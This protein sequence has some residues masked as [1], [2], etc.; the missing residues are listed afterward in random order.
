MKPRSSPTAR[1]DSL[2]VFLALVQFVVLLYGAQLVAVPWWPEPH[3]GPVSVF[4]MST[5]FECIAHSFIHHPFFRSRRLNGA[6]SV[7]N[8][9]LIGSPQAIYRLHH[10][11]ITNTT[12]TPP[13]PR[14]APP[15]TCPPPGDTAAGPGSRR[16]SCP[17]PCWATSAPT[18]ASSG[19]ARKRHL[20][21]RVYRE[22]AAVLA[23]V[24]AIGWL[25]P[26]GLVFFYLPVWY[27]GN[28]AAQAENFLEH[29]GAS[30]ATGRPTR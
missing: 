25:N 26:M 17:M 4:L 9:L 2:L 3:R 15:R 8:S 12:T 30:R 29:Y 20:I 23:L 27:F 21:R 10:L 24:V 6:F 1:L 19:E 7:F 11:T 14:R 22:F 18:S 5:N 16:A 28:A 13:T